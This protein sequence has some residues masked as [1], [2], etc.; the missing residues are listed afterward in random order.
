MRRLADSLSIVLVSGVGLAAFVSAVS[1]RDDA[2]SP[3]RRTPSPAS[4]AAAA[5]DPIEAKTFRVDGY[6]F[7]YPG[8]WLKGRER[9][10]NAGRR[11]TAFA[12]GGPTAVSPSTSGEALVLVVEPLRER[13]IAAQLD[14]YLRLLRKRLENEGEAVSEPPTRGTLAGLPVLRSAVEFR[15]AAVRRYTVI[16]DTRRAYLLTCTFIT[17]E[18]ERGCDQVEASFRPE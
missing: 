6:S 16:L 8:A 9:V 3:R 17:E 4:A 14:R 18:M 15:D 2:D 12:R 7:T 11:T 1:P 13:G 5:R 10:T